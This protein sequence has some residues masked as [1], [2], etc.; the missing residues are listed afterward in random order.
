MYSNQQ[1]NKFSDSIKSD[2]QLKSPLSQRLQLLDSAAELYSEG[3]AIRLRFKDE[4]LAD[5]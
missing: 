3:G 4:K 2:Q 1:P 5:E